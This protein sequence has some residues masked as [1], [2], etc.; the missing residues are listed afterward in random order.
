[1]LRSGLRTARSACLY[2]FAQRRLAS[3]LVLLEHKGGKLNES[4][5]S[6]V[7]AAKKLDGETAGIVVGSKAEVDG[8]LEQVKKW[9]GDGRARDA[10]PSLRLM[11]C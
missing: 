9:V 3:S 8:I 6:A 5:L 11:M 10:Y 2:S 7:T 1:M 4:S